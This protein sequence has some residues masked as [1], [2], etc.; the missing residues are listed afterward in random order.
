M[1]VIANKASQH[2]MYVHVC[3]VR[4]YVDQAR[5]VTLSEVVQ[6]TS[7]VEVRQA[8]HVLNLLK[9]RWVHLLCIVNV[10]FNLLQYEQ[11]YC[12]A[13]KEHL[14]FV[15]TYTPIHQLQDNFV[16]LLLLHTGRLEGFLFVR[17]PQPLL[18]VKHFG[19][20]EKLQVVLLT[21][22]HAR[23]R[24]RHLLLACLYFKPTATAP[25]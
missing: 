20:L 11:I 23:I 1:E 4:T 7:F 12:E 13:V 22:V 8:G 25:I 17:N 14:I 19:V 5:V 16:S 6:Y 15:N 18:R 9:L 2:C 21:Q 3:N 10:N 24:L